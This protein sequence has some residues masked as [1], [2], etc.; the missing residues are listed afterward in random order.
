MP[1]RKEAAV[2][3]AIRKDIPVPTVVN[4]TEVMMIVRV[5]GN[6]TRLMKL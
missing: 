2:P 4:K 3:A 1:T 6:A 5:D